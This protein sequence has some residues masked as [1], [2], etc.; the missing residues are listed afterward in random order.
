MVFKTLK[1]SL[2]ATTTFF[3]FIYNIYNSIHIHS[4]STYKFKY[5]VKAVRHNIHLPQSVEPKAF[6]S[7]CFNACLRVQNDGILHAFACVSMVGYCKPN[8]F[9]PLHVL[10]SNRENI[11][12]ACSLR[13]QYGVWI[14]QKF[15]PGCRINGEFLLV[16]FVA[17]Q[18]FRNYFTG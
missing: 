15:I 18:L 5:F 2:S 4:M 8:V 16:A 6:V 3:L 14:F 11:F 10:K 9:H 13:I 12:S 1:N 17:T 7:T